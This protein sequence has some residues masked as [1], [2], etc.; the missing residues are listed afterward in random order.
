MIEIREY[1]G[2]IYISYGFF[3]IGLLL[4]TI[5]TLIGK[6]TV[7]RLRPNFLDV[8]QPNV[9]PYSICGEAHITGKYQINKKLQT[10]KETDS[11][12]CFIGKTYLIPG[13]DFEC[14]NADKADIQESQLSFPSGHSSTSFYTAIF[15]VCYLNQMWKRRSCNLLL[16]IVQVFILC[17]AFVVVM[18]RVTDNKHHVTDVIAGSSVGTIVALIT[19]YYLYRFYKVSEIS[20]RNRTKSQLAREDSADNCHISQQELKIV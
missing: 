15:L 3:F 17:V 11:L 7:G 1:I 9:N 8:C 14:T 18:T 12:F 16:H 5:V 6:K 4:N 20:I 13:V 19:F 10:N 2:N